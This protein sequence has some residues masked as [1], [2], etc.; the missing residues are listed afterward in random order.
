MP[1]IVLKLLAGS[2][3]ELYSF[4]WRIN[5]YSTI[6]PFYLLISTVSNLQIVDISVLRAHYYSSY[7]ANRARQ[8]SNLY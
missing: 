8:V 4:E 3:Y 1:S 7:R 2:N 5:T 6:N